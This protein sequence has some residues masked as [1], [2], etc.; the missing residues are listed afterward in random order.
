MKILWLSNSPLVSTGYGTQT[1][2]IVP[3]LTDL[4]HEVAVACNWGLEGATLTWPAP[5][6]KEIRLYPRHIDTFGNDI[7][8]ANAKHFGADA[9]VSL[10]DSWVMAAEHFQ[11]VPWIAYAPVD[12][13][14][15]PPQVLR[16]LQ[17][18][19]QPI[20][21]SRFG[22]DR[23][24]AGRPDLNL[25]GVDALYVPHAVDCQ[26]FSPRPQNEARERIGLPQDKFIALMVAANKGNAPCRKAF[27]E[28][29][30]AFARLRKRHD[31]TLLF[32]HTSLGKAGEHAGVNIPELVRHHGLVPTVDVAAVDEY[33][34]IIGA[35]SDWMADL[36]SSADVLLNVAMGEG[37]GIPI[38]ESLSCGTPVIVGD[39]TSMSELCLAGWAVPKDEAHPV[40]TPQ[41]S[42]QFS[43]RVGAIADR[44]EWAY[45]Q[46]GSEQ[47]RRKAREGAEAYDIRRVAV[48]YWK[49]ALEAIEEKIRGT[50][51]AV[52]VAGPLESRAA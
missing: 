17:M 45:R 25:S 11:D 9:I 19:L 27:P 39:W 36:Y 33:Q 15:I 41:G 32:L 23:M 51:E 34:Y 2:L 49:P 37:F 44:L 50:P 21:Y 3:A 42:Y 14:P 5:N 10:Y 52:E 20:A 13:D 29:I 7:A 16:R 46:K 47:L 43:P 18:S 38:M 30:A 24:R 31:D 26:A 12:H 28:H 22:Q 8:A 6:G 35:R 40:W 4:G 48:E 1:A